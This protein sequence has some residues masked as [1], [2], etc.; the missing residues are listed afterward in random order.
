M[1]RE[2]I[3]TCKDNLS[4]PSP[5]SKRTAAPSVIAACEK[6]LLF[7][8]LPNHLPESGIDALEK[9]CEYKDQLTKLDELKKDLISSLSTEILNCFEGLQLKFLYRDEEYSGYIPDYNLTFTP[10]YLYEL[11]MEP[12]AEEHYYSCVEFLEDLKNS[13]LI[14]IDDDYVEW[15]KG[16]VYLIVHKKDNELLRASVP[17]FID[18]FEGF[19]NDSKFREKA[20][21][22]HEK[23]DLLLKDRDYILKSLGESLL[24]TGFRGDCRYLI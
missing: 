2:A 8:D 9:W 22:I 23:V 21:K 3:Q 5:H 4:E 6:H 16:D 1:L 19:I 11:V 15:G 24:Y 13:P 14:E 12:D 7:S 10:E 17:K 18:F 20:A